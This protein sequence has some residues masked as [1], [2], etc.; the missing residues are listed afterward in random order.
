M[1][2]VRHSKVLYGLTAFKY[3]DSSSFSLLSRDVLFQLSFT[4]Q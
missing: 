3:P 2:K 1:Q 4:V